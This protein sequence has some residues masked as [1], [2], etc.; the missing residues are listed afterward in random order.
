M[1]P[2]CQSAIHSGHLG[3]R[4]NDYLHGD[5]NNNI[6]DGVAG[7]NQIDGGGGNDTLIGG[8]GQNTFIFDPG[9]GNDTVVD[10]N[11]SQDVIEFTGGADGFA[12]FADLLANTTQV[13]LRG[14]LHRPAIQGSDG[15]ILL[16]WAN[17][18]TVVNG[19]PGVNNN[20]QLSD[21]QPQNVLIDPGSVI[22]DPTFSTVGR[23][24]Q[25][26]FSNE[27]YAVWADLT[28]GE[29]WIRRNGSW[30]GSQP[31][32]QLPDNL[33]G[34]SFA[35][36]SAYDDY[37]RASSV[38]NSWLQGGAGNDTLVFSG[39]YDYLGG[40][41]GINTADFSY[42]TAP[43]WVDPGIQRIASL[44]IESGTWV[45]IANLQSIQD[46]VG[47][48]YGG[49]LTVTIT[50]TRS[51]IKA[52]STPST[53]AVER[54][55]SICRSTAMASNSTKAIRPRPPQNADDQL[56]RGGAYDP[57]HQLLE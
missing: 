40:G 49:M 51:F 53:A 23:N 25:V 9:H 32:Y 55:R 2:D 26:D 4:Y 19:A 12:T 34:Y 35:I 36:G 16:E 52:A 56:R 39:Q 30:V 10:F 24:A 27:P 13:V 45:P 1:D 44:G 22:G 11:P 18:P 50:T 5:Q 57:I 38:G 47:S 14:R 29:D 37:L 15:T 42:V 21:L 8:R 28:T 3:H 43:V 54:I 31:W 20:L 46:I 6:I 48:P 7:N 41:S 17:S 33:S